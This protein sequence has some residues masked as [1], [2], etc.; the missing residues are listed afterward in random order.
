MHPMTVSVFILGLFFSL[1]PALAEFGPEHYHTKWRLPPFQTAIVAKGSAPIKA[2]KSLPPNEAQSFPLLK[3][4]EALIQNKP[5]LALLLIDEN[6]RLVFESYAKGA[7][8]D[9]L[10]VGHS[11]SKS[12]ASILIGQFLCEGSI[13][14]LTDRAE[15]YSKSLQATAYGDATIRDLLMMASSGSVAVQA[16]Q[17]EERFNHDLMVTHKRSLKE[18]LIEFG[19]N[20]KNPAPKGSFSYKGLDTVALSFVLSEIKKEK[21]Q[22][23]ISDHLWTKIGAE[24]NAEIVIDKNQDGLA[25]SGF[26]ATAR[27]WARLAIFVRD[28]AKTNSCYGN[29][30]KDATRGQI[31]NHSSHGPSFLKYGYQFWTDNKYIT[32]KTAWFNGYGGQLIGM[33]LESGKIIVLLSY[34]TGG[35]IDTYKLFNRWTQ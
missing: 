24:K 11:M 23:I 22:K 26:G 4:A 18:A 21:Y 19:R 13:H 33:D 7:Q 32:A 34:A 8:K 28:N 2:L 10:L 3:D 9:A 5:V 16:G 1:S 15:T 17:P 31:A 14:A 20:Q 27:D 25:Q 6:N 29:Y 30:L 12:I 35:V